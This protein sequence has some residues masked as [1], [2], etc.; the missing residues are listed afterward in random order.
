GRNLQTLSAFVFVVTTSFKLETNNFHYCQLR[1]D[2][3]TIT[4]RSTDWL[5][6]ST[7]NAVNSY[8]CTKHFSRTEVQVD[9]TRYVEV[10]INDV[11]GTSNGVEVVSRQCS[12]IDRFQTTGQ[13]NRSTFEVQVHLTVNAFQCRLELRQWQVTSR[14]LNQRLTTN[15]TELKNDRFQTYATINLVSVVQYLAIQQT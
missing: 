5:T 7:N 2:V 13:R 8:G 4:A 6:V 15:F 9:A 1:N 11:V 10:Q 12:V 3:C 14:D